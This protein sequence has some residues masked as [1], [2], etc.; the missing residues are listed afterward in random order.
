M[1]KHRI[2]LGDFLPPYLQD[3]FYRR[4]AVSYLDTLI[5]DSLGWDFGATAPRGD[6][7]MPAP[8]YS[9]ISRLWVVRL[10]DNRM[11]AEIEIWLR[12]NK[13]RWRIDDADFMNWGRGWTDT[14]QYALVAAI[15]M[16]LFYEPQSGESRGIL[17]EAGLPFGGWPVCLDDPGWLD[18]GDSK[19]E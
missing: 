4:L 11:L 17:Q 12:D 7:I 15:E 1:D 8:T 9:Y 16:M 19:D 2:L 14:P 13:I 10:K 18:R 3:N 5:Q 6:M